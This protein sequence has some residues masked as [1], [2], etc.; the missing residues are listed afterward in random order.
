MRDRR[1][2]PS[3]KLALAWMKIDFLPVFFFSLRAEYSGYGGQD[4]GGNG[5][6]MHFSVPPPPISSAN[7]SQPPPLGGGGGGGGAG[8]GYGAQSATGGGYGAQNGGL[9]SFFFK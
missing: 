9:L 6:G 8:G 4:Y 3:W 7:F 5:A 2:Q 1:D